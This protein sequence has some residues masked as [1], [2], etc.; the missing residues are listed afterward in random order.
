MFVAFVWLVCVSPFSERLQ[1]RL[2]RFDS[3]G[4]FVTYS[5]AA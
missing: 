2:Q 3:V 4:G 1:R 5:I